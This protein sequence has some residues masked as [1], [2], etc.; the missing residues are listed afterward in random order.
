MVLELPAYVCQKCGYSLI[1]MQNKKNVEE[2]EKIRPSG[3]CAFLDGLVVLLRRD[4]ISVFRKTK[5]LSPEHKFLYV[6]GNYDEKTLDLRSSLPKE[7]EELSDGILPV[8]GFTAVHI[9]RNVL[10]NPYREYTIAAELSDK[11]FQIVSKKLSKRYPNLCPE[12][13]FKRQFKI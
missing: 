10:Y 2:H 7:L 1:G 9:K 4:R 13:G 8:H 3:R 6:W 11:R 12:T 5:N